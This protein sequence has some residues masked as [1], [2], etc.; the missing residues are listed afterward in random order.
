MGFAG[1]CCGRRR[2][3][4]EELERRGRGVVEFEELEGEEEEREEG[5][6]GGKLEAREEG[7]GFGGGW[8]E[9]GFLEK[10]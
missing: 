2:R 3:E 1:G 6:R 10:R 8:R 7:A 5:G 4:G 9:G